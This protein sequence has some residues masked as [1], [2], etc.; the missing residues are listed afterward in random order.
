MTKI[1]FVIIE[2]ERTVTEATQAKFN[3]ALNAARDIGKSTIVDATVAEAKQCASMALVTVR[4]A[5]ATTAAAAITGG[6]AITTVTQPVIGT[7]E[8]FWSAVK[9]AWRA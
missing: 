8:T 3:A 4:G 6:C 1:D 9:A 7:V 5:L 2:T